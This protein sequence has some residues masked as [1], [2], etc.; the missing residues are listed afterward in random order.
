MFHKYGVSIKSSGTP[1]CGRSHYAKIIY[2]HVV[3]K[4]HKNIC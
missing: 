3:L 1:T 2:T 4:E